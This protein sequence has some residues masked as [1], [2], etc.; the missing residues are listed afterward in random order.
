MVNYHSAPLDATFHALADPTRRAILM[1]LAEGPSSVGALAEPFNMSL[2]AVSK[3]LRVLS[4]AGLLVQEKSGRV[5]RCILIAK[6]M[7]DAAQWIR[8]YRQFWEGQ[9]DALDHFLR[10]TKPPLEPK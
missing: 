10:S 4:K 1:Q 3:H 5:R 7:R 6:P 2:P 8:H 9:L